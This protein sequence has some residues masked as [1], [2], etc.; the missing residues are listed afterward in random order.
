MDAIQEANL[1][2]LD[3]VTGNMDYD[4]EKEKSNIAAAQAAG[5]L[6]VRGNENTLLLDLDTSAG[7]EQFHRMYEMVDSKFKILS[8]ET[9]KSKSGHSH[10]KLLIR[11][12]LS[13]AQR[14]AL[15]AVLGSDPKRE[16]FGVYKLTKGV[17]E[18]SILFRPPSSIVEP[19]SFGP[20]R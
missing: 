5:F 10:V 6:I 13:A 18:P 4:W 15:Q 17:E 12:A 2:S 7:L 9:W 16:T 8:S 14:I 3:E 1:R 19:V 11:E 20:Y